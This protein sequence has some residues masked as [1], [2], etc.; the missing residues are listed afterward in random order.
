VAVARKPKKLA[1]GELFEY[2]VKSLSARAYSAGD[3]KSKLRMRAANV[4][5]VDA[6]IDRLKDIGYLDDKRFA[7]SYASA[8]VENEGFGH[9]RVMQDLRARRI[10]GTTAEQAVKQAIGDRTEEQLIDAFMARRMGSLFAGGPI[11]DERKL[12]AAYRKLRRAGFTSGGILKAL[13]GL[14]ARPEEIEEPLE[15]ESP[16]T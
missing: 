15:D 12:A 4:A 3:L 8:R 11:E 2:A 7:E 13:K 9:M 10:A 6:A 1:A 16:D 14:A 5:D